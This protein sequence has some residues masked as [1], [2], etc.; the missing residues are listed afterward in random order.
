MSK[1]DK[2]MEQY[3][4]IIAEMSVQPQQLD[5]SVL[6]G[7]TGEQLQQALIDTLGDEAQSSELMAALVNNPTINPNATQQQQT[8]QGQQA[9]PTNNTT[10]NATANMAD[11]SP[12]TPNPIARPEKS[13]L[14]LPV[15]AQR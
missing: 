4:D 3:K 1:F 9:Q 12:S 10:N 15:G 8:A 11:K 7:A 6:D 5:L 2:I 13:A 14:G